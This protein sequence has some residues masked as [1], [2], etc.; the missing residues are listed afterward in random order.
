MKYFNRQTGRIGEGIA[1]QYLVK[2]GYEVITRNFST[3]FGEIDLIMR[4]NDIL[5]FVEVKAK[6][7]LKFGLPEE[8]FTQSKYAK[9]KRMATVYLQ[10]KEVPCRI[11]MVAVILDEMN[12]VSSVRHYENVER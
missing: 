7:G 1:E 5:V 11:D 12:T 9:V 2:K 8:M 10:G 3:R 4:D 6:K